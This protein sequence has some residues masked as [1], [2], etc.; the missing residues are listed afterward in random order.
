MDALLE[1]GRISWK[2]D[3]RVPI[4]KKVVEIIKEDLPILSLWKPV[5]G[6]ALRNYVK[7]YREGFGFRTFHGG[8][9]KYYWLD[10]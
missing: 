3:D 4:Y 9:L 8:G 2:G 7:G 5:V 6:I 1:K 10:K